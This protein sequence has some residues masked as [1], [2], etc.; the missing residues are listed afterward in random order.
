MLADARRN[1]HLRAHLPRQKIPRLSCP[2]PWK[3]PC[4]AGSDYDFYRGAERLEHRV[5][6]VHRVGYVNRHS[7]MPMAKTRMRRCI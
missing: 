6:S 2:P 5:R 3:Y 4:G 1:V 7:P